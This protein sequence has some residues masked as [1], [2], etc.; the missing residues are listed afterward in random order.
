MRRATDSLATGQ[1]PAGRARDRPGARR[2]LRRAA[3]LLLLALLAAGGPGP[4]GGQ[5]RPGP[6]TGPALSGPELAGHIPGST[7]YRRGRRFGVGWQW[8]GHVRADGTRV[9]RAWWG[10]GDMA[11]HGTWRATAD[12]R[13]CQLWHGVGW[14]EGGENC[15]RIY[16]A[17]EDLFWRHV[18]GPHEESFRF[19][20]RPGNPFGLAQDR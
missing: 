16:P 9:G 2:V 11:G 8:A 5:G 18:S 10:F 13:W 7:L 1:K 12:G 4:A 15:Y 3:G 14:S 6:A 20:M 17:G 19:E